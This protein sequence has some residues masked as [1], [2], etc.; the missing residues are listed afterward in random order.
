MAISW[1]IATGTYQKMKSDVRNIYSKQ[2][3]WIPQSMQEVPLEIYHVLLSFFVLGFGLVLSKFVFFG[4]HLYNLY[5]KR[6]VKK[7]VSFTQVKERK[8]AIE[9]ERERET[10]GNVS[11]NS[12]NLVVGDFESRPYQPFEVRGEE[13]KPTAP[14]TVPGDARGNKRGTLH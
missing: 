2:A 6:N 1:W 9:I 8:T 11:E 5:R 13:K 3:Y 7:S 4:E 12:R 10:L 14:A